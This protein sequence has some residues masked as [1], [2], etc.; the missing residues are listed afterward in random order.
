VIGDG[1]VERGVVHLK[2]LREER[3]E[4]ELPLT[5]LGAILQLLGTP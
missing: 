1:E 3:E 4:H 5:D 2:P